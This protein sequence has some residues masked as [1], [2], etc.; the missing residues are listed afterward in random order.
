MRAVMLLSVML[1]L[2]LLGFMAPAHAQ[3]R[4]VTGQ[5]GILGEWE[6]TATVTRR[7]TDSTEEFVGPLSLKH[8][9]ICTVDGAEEKKGELRLRMSE[10]ST[11]VMGTLLIDGS[12]CTYNVDLTSLDNGIMNC[13]DRRSVP[14]VLSIK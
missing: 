13:P 5:A 4:E 14:L 12:E 9:G 2:A 7:N 6:L 3:S 11:R 10:M 8:V 1:L